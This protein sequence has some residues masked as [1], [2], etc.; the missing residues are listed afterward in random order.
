MVHGDD[1]PYDCGLRR[2][3]RVSHTSKYL[4]ESTTE[5]S[6]VC[7]EWKN[8][9][10]VSLEQVRPERLNCSGPVCRG[11]QCFNVEWEALSRSVD[12][13]DCFSLTEP[14]GQ[15][16]YGSAESAAAVAN[17]PLGGAN[18]SMAP[19][20]TGDVRRH[21]FGNVVQ[22]AFLSSNGVG[23][24]VLSNQTLFVKVEGGRLCLA[25]LRRPFPYRYEDTEKR[26]MLYSICTGPSVSQMHQFGTHVLNPYARRIEETRRKVWPSFDQIVYHFPGSDGNYTQKEVIAYAGDIAG[27]RYGGGV[28]VLDSRWQAHQGDLQFDPDR[29]HNAWKANELLQRQGLELAVTISPVVELKSDN[30]EYGIDKELWMREEVTGDP[31]L[32]NLPGAKGAWMDISSERTQDWLR[33]KL[34]K[35][36]EVT[37][38]KWVVVDQTSAQLLA[39]LL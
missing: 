22:R 2:S 32:V 12:L 24:D 10:K 37:K 14:E 5:G 3:D 9:A 17:W 8:Q 20:V 6:E 36:K 30:I 21:A 18:Q 15:T 19:M 11:I 25:N 39:L 34:K 33:A 13:M 29:F 23:V 31:A 4:A 35:L 16:W 38:I 28:L 1:L 7:L 27:R 26:K